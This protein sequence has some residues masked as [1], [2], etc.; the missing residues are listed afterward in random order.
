MGPSVIPP[1]KVVTDGVPFFAL[2]LLDSDLLVVL[3]KPGF[4]SFDGS[5]CTSIFKTR[6][7]EWKQGKLSRTIQLFYIQNIKLNKSRKEL[8]TTTPCNIFGEN[9]FC[10]FQIGRSASSLACHPPCAQENI[11]CVLRRVSRRAFLLLEKDV[12]HMRG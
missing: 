9:L 10:I 12:R 8:S 5:W 4:S 7:R 11:N 1:M 6:I 2:Q 3:E